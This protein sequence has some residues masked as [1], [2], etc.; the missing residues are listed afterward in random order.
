MSDSS[1]LVTQYTTILEPNSTS[2]S[3]SLAPES[4]HSVSA[5]LLIHSSDVLD[6]NNFLINLA[7]TPLHMEV[8][9]RN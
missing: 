4:I 8:Q 3:S 1:L 6:D 9:L 5:N 2:V 7:L